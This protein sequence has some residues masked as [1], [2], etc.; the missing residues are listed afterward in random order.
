MGLVE[1]LLANYA[2]IGRSYDDPTQLNIVHRN[3]GAG[4]YINREVLCTDEPLSWI[5]YGDELI[6]KI[7][8]DEVLH[9]DKRNLQ[10][11]CGGQRSGVLRRAR[12]RVNGGHYDLINFQIAKAKIKEYNTEVDDENNYVIKDVTILRCKVVPSQ[13][14]IDYNVS[15]IFYKE[16]GEYI[17]APCSRCDCPH[18]T[19]LCS[20]MIGLLGV[21]AIIQ[22]KLATFSAAEIQRIMAPPI[23][24]NNNCLISIKYVSSDLWKKHM[25]EV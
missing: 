6:L 10:R 16:S 11:I 4:H 3:N 22:I 18:G 12:E 25:A 17:P 14:S 2:Y 24:R 15:L 7:R 20:H 13:R 9:C 8:S 1:N 23:R 5:G 19:L 21:I